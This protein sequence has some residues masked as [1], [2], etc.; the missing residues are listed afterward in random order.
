MFKNFL[1]KKML[2]SQGV[3]DQQADVI[4]ELVEKNPE[5]FQKIAGEIEQ[6]V[7][8]GEDKQQ[9][10]MAVMTAHQAELKQVIGDPSRLQL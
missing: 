1:I 10:A 6:R 7:K 2:K 9:A 8:S 5:L 3:S 4:L